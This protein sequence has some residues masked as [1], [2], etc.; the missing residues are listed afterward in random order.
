MQTEKRKKKKE[1]KLRRQQKIRNKS[2]ETRC[3]E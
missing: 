3:G 1:K 2:K